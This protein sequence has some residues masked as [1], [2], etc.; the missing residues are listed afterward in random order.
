MWISFLG[1]QHV[2]IVVRN[3][4]PGSS[5]A[6]NRDGNLSQIRMG[7]VTKDIRNAEAHFS[8]ETVELSETL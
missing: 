7:K 1:G 6:I 8:S 2:D 4:D 5:V 3:Y